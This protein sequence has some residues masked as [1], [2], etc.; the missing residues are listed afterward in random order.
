MAQGTTQPITEDMGLVEDPSFPQLYLLTDSAPF[1]ED[2][3][4]PKFYLIGS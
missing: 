4:N 3:N 2:P 1:T